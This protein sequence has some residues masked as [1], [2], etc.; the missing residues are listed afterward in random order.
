LGA[1]P[2]KISDFGWLLNQPIQQRRFSTLFATPHLHSIGPLVYHHCIAGPI[3]VT[4]VHFSPTCMLTDCMHWLWWSL[5]KSQC[6]RFVCSCPETVNVQSVAS[7]HAGASCAVLLSRH[8]TSRKR[9]FHVALPPENV[10]LTCL[11]HRKRW[12]YTDLPPENVG[13]YVVLPPE[14]NGVTWFYH[15]RKRWFAWFYLPQTMFHVVHP[16]EKD[17]SRDVTPR[18]R[19][20]HVI[21]HP[22][23]ACFA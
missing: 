20:L 18:K 17:Y 5:L 13:V 19:G 10:D 1:Q 11:Y 21:W 6:F 14:H 7:I 22:E 16:P 12:L 3:T 4:L 15:P 2:P 9:W 23:N 8:F